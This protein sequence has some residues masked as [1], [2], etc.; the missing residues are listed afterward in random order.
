M[1]Q[2]KQTTQSNTNL[3]DADGNLN[4]F[5]LEFNYYISHKRRVSMT[6][7]TYLRPG[8]HDGNYLYPLESYILYLLPKTNKFFLYPANNLT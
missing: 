5:C 4:N 1:V 3:I 7:S 6:P 2:E 8:I